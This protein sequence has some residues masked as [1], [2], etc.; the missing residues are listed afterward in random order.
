MGVATAVAV[1]TW[2]VALVDRFVRRRNRGR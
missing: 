1:G 2:I